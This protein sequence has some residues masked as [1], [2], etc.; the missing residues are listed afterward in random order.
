[1]FAPGNKVKVDVAFLEDQ[2]QK[3][4]HHLIRDVYKHKVTGE[5]LGLDMDRSTKE[6]FRYWVKFHFF[7]ILLDEKYLVLQ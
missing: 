7:N 3:S 5:V 4:N 2:S 1:M 6:T